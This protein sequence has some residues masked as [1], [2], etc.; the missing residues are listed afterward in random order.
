M[1][2]DTTANELSFNIIEAMFHHFIARNR[3]YFNVH[4]FIGQQI[5]KRSLK[6]WKLYRHKRRHHCKADCLISDIVEMKE[7]NVIPIHDYIKRK[8]IDLYTQDDTGDDSDLQLLCSILC[9]CMIDWCDDELNF[10]QKT[11]PFHEQKKNGWKMKL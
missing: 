8:W 3:Y 4:I 7:M 2:R 11:S 1:N 9:I 5:N 10:G 6:D